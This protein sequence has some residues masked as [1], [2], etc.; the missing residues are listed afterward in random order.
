MNNTIEKTSEAWRHDKRFKPIQPKQEKPLG[1]W[2]ID[3]SSL[4]VREQHKTRYMFV[5]KNVKLEIDFVTLYNWRAKKGF[6]SFIPH[7]S[8]GLKRIINDF[9][10][11]IGIDKNQIYHDKSF[12]FGFGVSYHGVSLRTQ[13]HKQKIEHVFSFKRW[14]YRAFKKGQIKTS[15]DLFAI[16]R[17]YLKAKGLEEIKPLVL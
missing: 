6:F 9:V 2:Y 5:R 10:E 4:A 8:K 12:L 3:I 16:Y 14:V 1:V 13:Q 7:K 15:K 17:K 11:K